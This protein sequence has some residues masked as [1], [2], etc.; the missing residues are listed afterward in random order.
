MRIATPFSTVSD[1]TR[2]RKVP[3]GTTHIGDDPTAGRHIGRS[4]EPDRDP[5][6]LLGAGVTRLNSPSAS[7]SAAPH[8][9]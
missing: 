6:V 1:S 5:C 8:Q 4:V 2:R 9:P 3:D 7:T